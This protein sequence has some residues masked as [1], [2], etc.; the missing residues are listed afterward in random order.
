MFEFSESVAHAPFDNLFDKD[1]GEK[2]KQRLKGRKVP[3][4]RYHTP[5]TRMSKNVKLRQMGSDRGR[6][7]YSH[8]A[9]HVKST[10]GAFCGSKNPYL[11]PS[12]VSSTGGELRVQQRI[13][14]TKLRG[15]LKRASGAEIAR[16]D[17]DGIV[18]EG[19]CTHEGHQPLLSC[20]EE[21]PGEVV[22][23]GLAA[24]ADNYVEYTVDESQPFGQRH[25]L[26]EPVVCCDPTSF[27]E[28][29][30]KRC[31]NRDFMDV[32]Q[33]VLAH[34]QDAASLKSSMR[35]GPEG[36]IQYVFQNVDSPTRIAEALNVDAAYTPPERDT[37]DRFVR[38]D[39][40]TFREDI[41]CQAGDPLVRST[42]NKTLARTITNTCIVLLV[43]VA[44]AV[45]L[46]FVF[47]MILVPSATTSRS[48]HRPASPVI[49]AV[50]PVSTPVQAPP[51]SRVSAHTTGSIVQSLRKRIDDLLQ[52]E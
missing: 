36:K 17:G 3:T 13:P 27:A 45:A 19:G 30:C 25:S 16:V 24:G 38:G 47:R 11:D 34:Q 23:E 7:V 48:V 28:D 4:E 31:L 35:V 14:S 32:R 21:G 1:P 52:T 44:L 39:S 5:V 2:E 20:R 41:R 10:L 50:K 12:A 8:T 29:G 43:C 33:E 6:P 46:F 37:L 9:N 18:L 51:R 40:G 49:V 15:L 26:V 42:C 22:V